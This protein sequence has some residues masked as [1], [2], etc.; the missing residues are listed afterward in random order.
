MANNKINQNKLQRDLAYL[1]DV[2]RTH[3]LIYEDGACLYDKALVSKHYNSRRTYNDAIARLEKAGIIKYQS[4]EKRGCKTINLYWLDLKVIKQHGEIM[5]YMN[6]D[7]SDIDEIF[8]NLEPLPVIKEE[9]RYIAKD[10]A[11]QGKDHVIRSNNPRKLSRIPHQ[12]F[13]RMITQQEFEFG[14]YDFDEK[15]QKWVQK[16]F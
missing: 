9:K 16:R 7:F 5:T 4:S 1:A 11:I 15:M 6:Q 12:Q 3:G 2:V 8:D 10:N 14:G 13:S